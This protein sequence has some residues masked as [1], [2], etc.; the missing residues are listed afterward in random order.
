MNR[1]LFHFRFCFNDKRLTMICQ[2]MFLKVINSFKICSTDFT[3]DN[4]LLRVGYSVNVCCTFNIKC[5][6]FLLL[7]INGFIN[8]SVF[9]SYI[10]TLCFTVTI[11][12]LENNFLF[13][14]KRTGTR[15]YYGFYL[16]VY[17]T[18][19]IYISEYKSK[20]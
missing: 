10:T 3:N 8:T 2:M 7:N 18:I 15:V 5:F 17:R 14:C 16:K 19:Y 20:I 12:A 6:Y 13:R 11:M 9:L 1:I 4:S